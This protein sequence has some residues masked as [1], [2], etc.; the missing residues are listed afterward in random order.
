MK[1]EEVCRKIINLGRADQRTLIYSLVASEEYIE[2]MEIPV[3][4]YGAAIRID[5]RDE[6]TVIGG[7]TANKDKALRL[8]DLLASNFVTP[9]ALYD[10]VYDW[11]E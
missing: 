11:I 6:S 9:V 5:E 7:I 4:C 8:I 1:M 10:V 3:K 2:D